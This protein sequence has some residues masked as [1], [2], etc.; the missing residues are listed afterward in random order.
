MEHIWTTTTSELPP[1]WTI[2][3]EIECLE[4]IMERYVTHENLWCYRRF[5]CAH[6]TRN[7]ASTLTPDALNAIARC[8]QAL[9]A[10]ED[11]PLPTTIFF[12]SELHYGWTCAHR[13]DNTKSYALRYVLW[14]LKHIRA[15]VP[16]QDMLPAEAHRLRQRVVSEL[17]TMQDSQHL[18]YLWSN[19]IN[20]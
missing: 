15:L 10:N 11:V 12:V 17:G 20:L 9:L 18:T 6:W 7:Q 3:H 2:Q 14:V 19:C 4:R 1:E 13:A 5:L 8:I 16:V